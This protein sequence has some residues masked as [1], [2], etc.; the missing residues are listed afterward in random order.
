ME[1]HD[2]DTDNPYFRLKRH[3]PFIFS[4]VFLKTH[5]FWFD[6]YTTFITYQRAPELEDKTHSPG[7]TQYLQRAALM[8]FL[9]EFQLHCQKE[10]EMGWVLCLI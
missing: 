2:D 10:R 8:E 1:P 7:I 5:S 6:W 4:G 3:Q 9:M